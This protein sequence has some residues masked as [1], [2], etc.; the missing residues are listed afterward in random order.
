MSLVL[1]GAT[2]GLA[3]PAVA[4]ESGHPDGDALAR[5]EVVGPVIRF[6][7]PLT[8]ST[9]AVARGL[10]AGH[11]QLTELAIRS[12]GGDVEAG[13]DLGELVWARGLGVR[14][15]GDVCGS[16]CAN[17]VFPAGR[18]KI[19]DSGA[20]VIWHGSLLQAGLVDDLD[21]SA[22]EQQLG[23]PATRFEKWRLKRKATK[24]FHR[25]SDRQVAFFRKI[26][27]DPAI[28][29][30]GQDQG[31]DCNWTVS[32]ADMATFGIRD[33][34]ADADYGMPGYGRWDGQ[35]QRV[36]AA[37]ARAGGVR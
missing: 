33:V 26:G 22:A 31:C 11:A 13:M 12:E 27:V 25:V 19:V 9:V 29:V 32:V 14:V 3:S 23:R 10:L 37:A 2:V 17:Y 16:S 34:S 7:G 21:F 18:W 24:W 6:D 8:P 30:L 5:I 28:T 4:Q 20:L 35:W 15:V 36:E 1:L